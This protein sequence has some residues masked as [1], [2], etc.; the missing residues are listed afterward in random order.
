MV[1]YCWLM[2]KNVKPENLL[3]AT[4]KRDKKRSKAE[5]ALHEMHSQFSKQMQ[6]AQQEKVNMAKQ[7][8]KMQAQLV[9]ILNNNS[10]SY[11]PMPDPAT[12]EHSASLEY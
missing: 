3:D 4:L 7:M 9:H 5:R 12:L 11:A 8:A 6:Q 1:V 2:G 10:S